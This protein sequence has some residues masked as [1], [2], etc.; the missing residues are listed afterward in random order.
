MA[1]YAPNM[2]Y[3]QSYL[4]AYDRNEYLKNLQTEW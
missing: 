2:C 4:Q 3:Q 1:I